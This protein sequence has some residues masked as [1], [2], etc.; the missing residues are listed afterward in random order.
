[1]TTLNNKNTEQ[2]Q[3]LVT[4]AICLE[5]YKDPRVLPCSHTFCFKCIQQLVETDTAACPFRDNTTIN[6]ND[7]NQL[8]INRTAKDMVECITNFNPSL[9]TNGKTLCDNCNET[10]GITWCEKCAFHYC[11]SCTKSVHSVKALQS[12]TIVPVSEKTHSFCFEHSDERYKYWCTQC[13]MLVCPDCLLFKHKDHTFLLLTD[14]TTDAK[15]NLEKKTQEINEI[16][17][18]LTQVSTT[19]K[20]AISQLDEKRIQER[21]DIE[22]MFKNLQ[23]MLEERKCL[24]VKKL[25]D[26]EI[27]PIQILNQ[28]QIKID[29]HLNLTTVQEL[30]IRQIL[31]SDDPI[32]ILKFKSTSSH[33][34]NEFIEEYKKIDEGCIIMRDTFT[35][36]DKDLEDLKDI[37]SKLGNIN[38]ELYRINREVVAIKTIPLDI[39]RIDNIKNN[40]IILRRRNTTYAYGYKFSLKQPMKLRS[41][42]IESSNNGSHIGF[43]INGAGLII[44]RGAADSNDSTMKWLII[45]LEGDIKNDY[46]VLVW[47]PSRNGSYTHKNGDSQFRAINHNCEVQSKCISSVAQTD[48]GSGTNITDSTYSID[49][50]LDIIE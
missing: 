41:I 12:H 46:T 19:I 14:A 2:L 17:R 28:H 42:R 31:N 43:V 49:M 34:Y 13:H 32:Q 3:E 8:P 35:R 1:M 26:E 23:R 6:R 21:N 15:G 16:K 39:S 18:N 24:L 38:S 36:N 48:I 10:P 11:E 20:N 25:E 47:T 30:C 33:N 40:N 7:I 37:I 29:Q 27:Q 9:N 45:P 50:I 5:Y 4:C 22:Q 44:H